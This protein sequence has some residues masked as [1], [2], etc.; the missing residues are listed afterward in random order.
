MPACPSLP[1]ARSP[2]AFTLVEALIAMALVVVVAMLALRFFSNLQNVWQHSMGRASTH[3]DGR[4]AL[5][6][7]ARDLRRA[8]ASTDERAGQE[9]RI[10][11]PSTSSLWF[12]TDSAA[13]ASV[14]CT[15]VE[16]G[17]RL[18]EDRLERAC[19][20]QSSS[21]WNIYGDR[22]DAD[23]Q[24][25]Y[26]TV[27][28]G[29]VGLSFTCYDGQYLVVTPDQTSDMP[30]L[31]VVRLRVLDARDMKRWRSLSSSARPAFERTAGRTFW[32]TVQPR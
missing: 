27:I 5:D 3:E 14:P 13:D 7:V 1:R 10:H 21:A 12:V 22:D 18:A 4:L 15:L 6:L 16:V 31:I 30:T 23:D 17:Y 29:V 2:R 9:I 20:D 24:G 8:I 28:D 26:R 11:Q 19:V 32:T 25:G